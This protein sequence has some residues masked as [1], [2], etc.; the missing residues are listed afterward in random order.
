[1]S[2]QRW[3]VGEVAELARVTVRTLH[4]YDEI[5]LLPAAE[6][7][8]AGYR[9]YGRAELERL[10]RILL[11]RE[12]DLSL[13]EIASILDDPGFDAE[14]ALR[15]QRELLERRLR[16]H[17]ALLGAVETAIRTLEEGG[18]M[19]VE[20]IFEG[21]GD[22][23]PTEHEAE[24]EERWG[25][26]EAYRTAAR[27]TREYGKADWALMKREEEAIWTRM[28]GR[29]A[30]GDPPT[31]PAAMEVAEEAR[32]HIDRW[33]YPCDRAMHVALAGMY[34]ADE[35]FRAFFEERAEGLAAYAAAA[36]RA[37]AER[38]GTE[39]V[40]DGPGEGDG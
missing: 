16:R 12:L 35:R 9:L 25:G 21:F 28:A 13:E 36:I 1:M 10:H 20:G 40:G 18:T 22:V 19:D 8:H 4:H 14:T 32:R 3:S 17:E 34:E 23:D 37:N 38:G 7:T 29:M 6:R 30:E 33:F 24:V 15:S 27:R 31:S 26:T 39:A 11:F 5:G 2:D